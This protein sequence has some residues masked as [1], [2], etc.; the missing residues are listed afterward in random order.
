LIQR[1]GNRDGSMDRTLGIDYYSV[2]STF[3]S[4]L[5]ISDLF[6]PPRLA[7]TTFKDRLA[8]AFNFVFRLPRFVKKYDTFVFVTP[9][10]FHSPTI[11]ILRILRK[12]VVTI[13]VDAYGE[14]AK[15]ELWQA[16]RSRTFIRKAF[17]P[18]YELSEY[19]SAKFSSAIFCVSKYL[20]NKCRRF[21]E[22]VYYV[23]NGADVHMISGIKPKKLDKDYIFFVGAFL[24][25]RGIDLLLKAFEEVRRKHDVK[26]VLVGSGSKEELQKYPEISELLK[27]KDVV[28]LGYLPHE[29]ALS[30]LKGAKIAVMPN[31]NTMLSRTISS[32]KVFEYAASEVPQVCTDSGEHAEW[33]KKLN[34]GIVVKDTSD[35][36]ARGLLELL[37]NKKLYNSL[38]ENCKRSKREIDYK[39]LWRPLTQ[40]FKMK[41]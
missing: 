4:E 38:K 22:N 32:M 5:K 35:D 25:W 9:P 36:I 24:K 14:I 39:V 29:E 7:V 37:E 41:G 15:E 40:Y 27:T 26:L 33:V 3:F 31:R 12:R 23:P 19:I 2:V 17:Y 18:L 34:V 21:N 20:V 6:L 8:H 11:P 10:Y 16:S 1:K 30:Y 28:S 13:V